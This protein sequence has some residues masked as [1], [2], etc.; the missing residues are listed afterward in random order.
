LDLKWFKLWKSFV[1]YESWDRS[2]FGNEASNPGPIDNSSLIAGTGSVDLT[3]M[4]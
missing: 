2:F 4:Q 1:G 3:L